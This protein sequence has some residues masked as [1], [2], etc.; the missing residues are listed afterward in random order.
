MRAAGSK[1][2][3]DGRWILG[4]GA[5]ACA[6]CCAGPILGFVTAIGAGTLLGYVL[7][8]VAGV[9]VLVL[10]AALLIRQR[11]RPS[12]VCTADEAAPVEIGRKA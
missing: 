6:A 7:F 3:K 1:T 2:S 9:G 4:V 11:R 12:R 5:V 8:G 10:G